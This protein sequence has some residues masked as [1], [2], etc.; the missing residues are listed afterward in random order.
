MT[1]GLAFI[2][3]QLIGEVD[4]ALGKPLAQSVNVDGANVSQRLVRAGREA[5]EQ[6]PDIGIGEQLIQ[7]LRVLHLQQGHFLQRSIAV[8]FGPGADA[9]HQRFGQRSA[10]NRR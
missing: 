10:M 6:R 9:A 7:C 4:T 1:L 2:S 8:M 3:L 5:L